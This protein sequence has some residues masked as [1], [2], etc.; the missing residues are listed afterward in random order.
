LLAIYPEKQWVYVENPPHPPGEGGA[1]AAV[2]G[3][4]KKEGK[5]VRKNEESGKI[6]GKIN[7]RVK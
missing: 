6:N 3:D 5:L 7:K 4:K 2:M 1:P